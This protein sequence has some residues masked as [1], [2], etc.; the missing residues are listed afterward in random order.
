MSPWL[1]RILLFVLLGVL[2]IAFGNARSKRATRV[3]QATED[4]FLLVGNGT[5]P[6]TLDPQI[7]TGVPEHHILSAI[8]EGLVGDHPSDDHQIL[9]GV[10][11]RWEHVDA[12]TWTFYLNPEARWTNGDSVQA[13]NFVYAYERILTP[14][15]GAE[16]AKLLY[17]IDGAEAFNLGETDDFSTV[18]VKAIDERTLE[19]R[20]VGPA[21]YFPS[22]LKHYA[23]FPIHPPTIEKYGAMTDRFTAWTRVSN[24]VSNG[25]FTLTH[26]GFGHYIEA[27]RSE[28]Y[29]NRAN[30]GLEGIRFFPI[31]SDTTEERAFRDGQL[32]VTNTMPADR[33]AYY[34]ENRP[35]EFRTGDGMVVYFYRC[36]T[37]SKEVPQLG[38]VRVRK[39]LALAIDRQSIVDNVTKGGQRAAYGL[40]PPTGG[41]YVTPNVLR[42]DPEKARALL[43]EAGYPA[44]KGFPKL[45]ILFNTSEGH[46]LIAQALQAMWS[47]HLGLEVE[48][49][50]Q[51]WK[52]YLDSQEKGDFQVCRAGWSADYI[53]PATFLSMWM[54]GNGHNQTGWSS[55]EY[56]ELMNRSNRTADPALRNAI[57]NQAETI[58]LDEVPAI[59]VYW[60]AIN[61]AVSPDVVG[62]HHKLLDSHPWQHLKVR[63]AGTQVEPVSAEEGAPV[64]P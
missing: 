36:N 28:T 41:D 29:W 19:I 55:P 59:P 4:G 2:V 48:L 10:A 57:M 32:H 51:D 21:P 5:E 40:V 11:E 23:F 52:V 53:D 34:R 42:F 44:G 46:R 35:D 58:F 17:Q 37:L 20:L 9:P 45:T 1:R 31:V 8:F 26:W 64:L 54:T 63:K 56:D 3:A 47:D 16:Y 43:A 49:L 13:S 39:A 24:M 61:R 25:P 18:G 12:T 62:W 38:D 6:A 22:M 27:R 30:V 7:A 60:Y 50:N 33:V 15:F 14:K